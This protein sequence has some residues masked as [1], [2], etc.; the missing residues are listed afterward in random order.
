MRKMFPFDDVIMVQNQYRLC[1]SLLQNPSEMALT[2]AKKKLTT[3]SN[4]RINADPNLLIYT[5]R[6]AQCIPP[7]LN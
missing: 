7:V 6:D 1:D 2:S 5:F 4:Q 3:V